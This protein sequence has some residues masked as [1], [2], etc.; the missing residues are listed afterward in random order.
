[1]RPI[2]D[3]LIR[4]HE[5]W[6]SVYQQLAVRPHTHLRRRLLALSTQVLSH[7]HWQGRPS[8]AWA[9]LHGARHVRPA[10]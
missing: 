8:R 1:M 6:H 3:D 4:V 10:T 7:P 2:P 9:A 5:E